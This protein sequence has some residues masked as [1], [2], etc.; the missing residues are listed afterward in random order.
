MSYVN[1]RIE[2]AIQSGEILTVTYNGGS[3]PGKVRELVPVRFEG[4][5]KVRAR[6]LESGTT[7]CFVI[8]KLSIINNQT[9]EISSGN[10]SKP[11]PIYKDLNSVFAELSPIINDSGLHIEFAQDRITVHRKFKNGKV[12]KGTVAIMEYEEFKTETIFDYESNEI[13]ETTRKAQRPWYIACD[14]KDSTTF[15]FFGNAAERFVVWV[16]QI[17][18]RKL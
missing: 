16:K 2:A 14:G 12:M 5:D 4:S 17:A 9:G 7:K 11:E 10:Y 3:T 8:E 15:K 18:L 6:C 13:I 1:Q